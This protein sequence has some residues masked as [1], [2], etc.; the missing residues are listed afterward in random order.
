VSNVRPARGS[1]VPGMAEIV[2]DTPLWQRHGMTQ[3]TAESALNGALARNEVV[4]VSESDERILGLAWVLPA[5]A[6]GRSP[7]LKWLGVAPGATSRGTGR[8]LLRAAE[9]EA[10]KLR[11]ELV[12]LCSDFNLDGQRFYEREGYARVGAIPDYVLSGVAE[13]IYF[14][15]L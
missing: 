5:G 6:F 11:P 4:L 14:K 7:Y 3:S 13:L 1:D 10:R 2:A 8:E 9:E 12:L 15:R